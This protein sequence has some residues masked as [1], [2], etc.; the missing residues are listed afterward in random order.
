MI[1]TNKLHNHH[2]FNSVEI[3]SASLYMAV[4]LI[5]R[6]QGL[7][8]MTRSL[9]DQIL[10]GQATERRVILCTMYIVD[11]AKFW[12]SIQ[13]PSLFQRWEALGVGH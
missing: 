9:F 12:K 2:Q 13:D 8:L 4:K 3:Q 5:E 7:Q 1:L 11:N 6:K 10:N